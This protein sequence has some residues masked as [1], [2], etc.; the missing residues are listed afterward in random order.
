SSAFGF[1]S[2][3]EYKQ[4]RN[5]IGGLILLP[6]SRNRSLNDKLYSEKK[7]VY[8]GENVLCQTLCANFYQNN[9]ELVRFL[10][11]NNDINLEEY[12]EFNANAITARGETYKNIALK[13]WTPPQ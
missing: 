2:D 4:K 6:R 9:P 7:T 5:L 3:T 8:S 10:S 1:S 11:A 13:I 12:V